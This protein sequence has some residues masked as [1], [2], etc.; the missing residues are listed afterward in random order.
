MAIIRKRVCEYCGKEIGY[1]GGH[2]MAEGYLCSSCK[3]QLLPLIKEFNSELQLDDVTINDII[4][5]QEA[6]KQKEAK[7]NKTMLFAC[8]SFLLLLIIGYGVYSSIT[9]KTPVEEVAVTE[10]VKEEKETKTATQQFS[11]S[12]KDAKQDPDP[13]YYEQQEKTEQEKSGKQNDIS[14]FIN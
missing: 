9:P 5:I 10:T 1:I 8:G 14:H 13:I 2:R 11:E 6:K 3:K 12:L 4:Q 7:E